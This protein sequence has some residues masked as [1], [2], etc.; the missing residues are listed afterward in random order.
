MSSQCALRF[1]F[2]FCGNELQTDIYWPAETDSVNVIVYLTTR[3]DCFILILSYVDCTGGFSIFH[4]SHSQG[5][6]EEGT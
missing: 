2:H 5:I 3:E 1:S 4:V 6:A